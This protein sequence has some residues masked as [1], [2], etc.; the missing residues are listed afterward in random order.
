M[1]VLLLLVFSLSLSYWCI[2]HPCD[3]AMQIQL[4]LMFL[5]LS[6]VLFSCF[7][8]SVVLLNE[9]HHRSVLFLLSMSV[10]V[11]RCLR[12]FCSSVDCLCF[13]LGLS[14]LVILL[15]SCLMILRAVV[16]LVYPYSTSFCWLLLL[17]LL[18]F[19]FLSPGLRLVFYL[20]LVCSHFEFG[21]RY[22][23]L[24]WI[25]VCMRWIFL[26]EATRMIA[27]GPLGADC[28]SVATLSVGLVKWKFL[29]TLSAI[30][31]ETQKGN[32]GIS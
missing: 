10:S 14:V 28:L 6:F 9:L 5:Q 7:S 11:M 24:C 15:L 22:C 20:W 27:I 21:C 8:W 31:V 19:E 30:L 18:R 17:S 13:S 32:K 3:V 25:F 29:L 26:I 16:D 12:L 1:S 23:W 4:L 2:A